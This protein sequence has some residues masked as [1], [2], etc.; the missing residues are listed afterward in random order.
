M[1]PNLFISYSRREVGFVDD[2][3]GHLEK[4]GF[5]TWLDY[6]SLEPGKPWK[7]QIYQGIMDAN[8]ILL[9]VSKASIASDNVEM[10]WQHVLKEKGK[11]ILLLIFETMDLPPELEHLEWVDFRGNYS[12][13]LQELFHQLQTP[14]KEKYPAP[15]MGFKVPSIVW[16]AM[17]LSAVLAI[18]SLATLWTLFIPFFLAPLPYRILKRNFR[19]LLVQGALIML[20]VALYLTSLFSTNRDIGDT[21][22]FLSTASIPFVIALLFVLRTPAMQRWGKPEAIKPLFVP[23]DNVSYPDPKPVSFFVEHAPQD[24][25]IAEEMSATLKAQGHLLA[26]DEKSAEAVFTLVSAFKNDTE[27]DCEKQVVY[28]VILQ[29]NAKA[30]HKLSR[31]QWLDFRYGVHH[32]DVVAKLLNQPGKLLRALCIR[33]AGNQLVLPSTILYLSYFIAFLAI[34][35]IGSWLPYLLQYSPEVMQSTDFDS[36]MLQ[37]LA[38]MILFGVIAFFMGRQLVSRKGFAASLPGLT[39][40]MLLLGGILYW[41]YL[42]DQSVFAILGTTV[43]ARGYSSYYP[44]YLYMIGNLIMIVYLFFKRAELKRWFPAR[45]RS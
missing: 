4:E 13:A 23:H 28:P 8:V 32:L 5:Q 15:Q 37:L 45:I 22:L 17:A 42:I 11:R 33:P 18:I 16:V 38:S 26:A 24:R 9:V 7:E 12:K 25:I 41:E 44:P 27:L 43:E 29:S 20:P 14:E 6:R 40:G 34:F 39:V 1:K 36:P 3:F 31:V 35:C 10:E 30:S 19:Y 2:L 21:A